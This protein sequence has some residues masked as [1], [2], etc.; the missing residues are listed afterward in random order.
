LAG[1]VVQ[2]SVLLIFPDTEL[3]GAEIVAPLPLFTISKSTGSA[4]LDSISTYMDVASIFEMVS[5][6]A[7]AVSPAILKCLTTVWQYADSTALATDP[8]A[9]SAINR[10]KNLVIFFITFVFKFIILIAFKK[11]VN[12]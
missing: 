1:A 9:A 10:K 6:I 5:L 7:E 8:E 4:V 2:V 3:S 12:G 11:F